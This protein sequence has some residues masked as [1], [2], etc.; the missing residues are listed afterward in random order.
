MNSLSLDEFEVYLSWLLTEASGSD[1]T[2]LELLV[3]NPDSRELGIKR[4]SSVREA[5][6]WVQENS[7]KPQPPRQSF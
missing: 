1:R 5:Q 4:L 6:R 7:I 2:T 3:K